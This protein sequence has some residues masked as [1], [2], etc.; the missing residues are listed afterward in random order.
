MDGKSWLHE[1]K[2][3]DIIEYNHGSFVGSGGGEPDWERGVVISQ[4]KDREHCFK[5]RWL[6]DGDTSVEVSPLIVGGEF[7][8]FSAP[9]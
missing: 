1:L 2:V 6:H 7:R 5:I 9:R 8:V 4:F 3:G